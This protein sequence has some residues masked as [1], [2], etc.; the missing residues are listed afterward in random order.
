MFAG[1]LAQP[2]E[3]LEGKSLSGQLEGYDGPLLR[4]IGQTWSLGEFRTE[5]REISLPGTSGPR[6][7]ESY[8]YALHADRAG[9]DGVQVVLRDVTENKKLNEKLA[10]VQ[11]LET[12]GVLA[13]GIA[14][15]FNN[16]LSGL[17]GYLELVRMNLIEGQ[18]LVAAGRLEKATRVFQRARGLTK[19]LL[20]FSK[21]GAPVL[22]VQNLGPLLSEWVGFALSGATN[23]VE[24]QVAPDLWP[25]HCD[26]QQ[27]AQ[28]VDNLLINARQASPEGSPL[29]V[30]AVNVEQEGRAL[31]RISVVDQGPGVPPELREK[32]FEPFF[33]TKT[34]GTGLGLATSSSI[35]VKHRGWLTVEPGP[36]RGSRFSLFLPAATAP[37]PQSPPG[38]RAEFRGSGTVL[39]VDDEE[40][41]REAVG[42]FLT[43]MGFSVLLA[44][45]E[46]EA[47]DLCSG[48]W[49]QGQSVVLGVLDLTTTDGPGG[50]EI[51]RKLRESG[52]P[53]VLIAMSGYSE[54]LAGGSP[55]QAGFDGYLTK[56]FSIQE[57]AQLLA[58]YFQNGSP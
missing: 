57:L 22:E 2:R 30:E 37:S 10:Q 8:W 11:K 43:S 17:W 56:P 5:A 23:S 3:N 7:L 58:G 32:I 21:G 50:I 46:R 36:T 14:H 54:E 44:A 40:S 27:I 26:V 18:P 29:V 13:G 31:V 28:V 38:T 12:I 55:L 24:L 16:I 47:L 53:M 4:V 51:C 52:H 39:V 6:W 25:C 19:Q 48:V 42:E 35:A 1:L 15:D 20:T 33:S 34:N 9:F 41:I 49:A 45:N